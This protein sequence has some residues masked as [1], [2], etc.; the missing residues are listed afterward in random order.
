MIDEIE[1]MTGYLGFG[2][3]IY[4][5]IHFFLRST[6]YCIHFSI[7]HRSIVDGIFITLVLVCFGRFGIGIQIINVMISKMFISFHTRKYIKHTQYD[8]N[9]VT[10]FL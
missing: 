3:Q 10:T 7:Q 5:S 9:Y 1:R 8:V 6:E 2:A 4:F